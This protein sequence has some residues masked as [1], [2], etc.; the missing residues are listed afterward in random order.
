M[1]RR[2]LLFLALASP[3]SATGT[4]RVE[5]KHRDQP[6]S[7]ASVIANGQSYLTDGDGVASFPSSPG[8]LELVIAKDGF[9]PI[10]TSLVVEEGEAHVVEVLLEQMTHREE[11]TVVAT[12]R[13]QRTTSN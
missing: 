10:S 1:W 4:V 9:L 8:I 2:V 12:T 7:G 3:A 11:V 13:S 5:V 6:L